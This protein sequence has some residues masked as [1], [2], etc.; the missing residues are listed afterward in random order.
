MKN[1]SAE[2]VVW[3]LEDLYL[4]P[5]D[6][7]IAAD[8]AWCRDQGERFAE[9]YKGKVAGLSPAELLKAIRLFEDLQERAQKLYSFAYL[10]FSTQT[11]NPKAS[12]LLQAMQEFYSLLHRDVLF[13]ELEWT[14]VEED[15]AKRVLDHPYLASYRHYLESVRRYR[16]HMLSE[17]EERLLAEKEPIGAV[18]WNTLFDKVLSQLRFGD[19]QRTESEVL[20]DLYHANREVR[21]QAAG[22]LTAGLNGVLHILTHIFNTIL[23]DKS[24]NDRLR[25]YPHWL[26]ARNLSNEADDGMVEA[27][28]AAASSRYDLVQRYYRLKRELLGYDELLDYDRY[29]P[30]PGMPEDRLPWEE[31]KKI[32]LSA[33]EDFSPQMAGIVHRFFDEAWIHAPVL[34]GKRSGAFAHPTVP[35]AHPYIL[36]NYTGTHRDIMT[37]AHE[38]GHGVHQFLARQ[39]GLFNSDTPLTTAESA[40]VFGEMLVFR[41][42]LQQIKDPRR[43]LALLCSKLEDIFATVFRQVSM[44]RFEDA[45]HNERRQKGELDADRISE[46]W[47]ETQNAMFGN[48]VRLQEHYRTWWS[49]IPHFLHSPGYVYAYAFGE[50]LV[51]ALYRQY[52]EKGA[53]FVPLYLDLLKAGGKASPGELLRPFGIDLS[54]ANF[55]HQGLEVLEELLVEAEKAMGEQSAAG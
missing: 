32:V 27:L 8:K 10:F 29:A 30:V 12:S 23:L 24:I 37:M 9:A 6:S 55:W 13:F 35:G 1:V 15:L 46:L 21:Q 2:E 54:D 41:Y 26:R 17:A 31:S 36:L 47:M 19:R 39:Q 33:Y 28:I 7:R 40:S 42:L 45:V 51:L 4:G 16:P 43:R 14:Q 18:A 34:P 52:Q 3:R 50:L 20:S 25:K 11:Q 5:E 49:Y 22:E 48:S 44:N 38:L 53:A